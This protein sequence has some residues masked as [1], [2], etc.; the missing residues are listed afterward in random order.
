MLSC[1]ICRSPKLH[2]YHQYHRP[3]KRLTRVMTLTMKYLLCLASSYLPLRF[4][5][6]CCARPCQTHECQTT[7]SL[8]HNLLRLHAEQKSQNYSE[9]PR[10]LTDSSGHRQNSRLRVQVEGEPTLPHTSRQ[11]RGLTGH[12]PKENLLIRYQMKSRQSRSSIFFHRLLCRTCL[13]ILVPR[14]VSRDLRTP[15]TSF[16]HSPAQ[17]PSDGKRVAIEDR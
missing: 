4:L 17:S 16:Y 6:I 9:R 2:L 10:R 3:L 1:G 5:L 12:S 11:L 8:P 13:E 15:K 7:S 14:R